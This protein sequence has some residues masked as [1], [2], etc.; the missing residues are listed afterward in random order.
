M[1]EELRRECALRGYDTVFERNGRVFA[2]NS[3]EINN[4]TKTKCNEFCEQ[5]GLSIF[6][7][8]NGDTVF[9]D[10]QYFR[11]G[12]YNNPGLRYIG[13]IGT[14]IPQPIGGH[15]YASLFKGCDSC[16]EIDLTSWDM[17]NVTDTA[18]MFYKSYCKSVNLSGVNLRKVFDMSRMFSHCGCL[19]TVNMLGVKASPVIAN[20]MFY[21][22]FNL[23]AVD[24]SGIDFSLCG[25]LMS[26]FCDCVNLEEVHFA[27]WNKGNLTMC[28]DNFTGCCELIKKTGLDAE[29]LNEVFFARRTT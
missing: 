20:G 29:E 1:K 10:S 13:T 24:I 26:L 4:W 9:Y 25:M 16:D 2:V 22:C 15:N 8:G 19:E 21:Q 18:E 5:T 6:T 14:D 3:K 23:K 12:G 7:D 28:Y 17:T 11:V 27:K